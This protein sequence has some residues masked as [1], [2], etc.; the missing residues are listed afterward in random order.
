MFLYLN[1]G[2]GFYQDMVKLAVPIILQNLVI[3]SLS[4]VDTF[5]VG[6][7]PGDTPMAAV[8]LAN[9]PV[10]MIQL[11]IFGLQSGASVLISQYWGK[12]DTAAIN[13]VLGIGL[14]AA[15]AISLPF[16][17]AMFC[18]PVWSMGLFSNNAGLVAEAAGYAQIVGFAYVLNSLT[19]VYIG[20]QRSMENPSTGLHI[21]ILSMCT[22]TFLNWVLIFGRLGAPAMGVRGAAA[23][24]LIS[25]MVEF[26][27]TAAYA[28]GCRRFSLRA[29]LMLRP[30]GAMLRSYARFSTPVVL[31]ETLWGLGTALYPTIMG[32]MAESTAILTAFTIAGNIDRVCTVAVFALANTAAII[33]GREIGAGRRDG[34]Y[35][36]GGALNAVAFGTGLILGGIM[37]ASTYLII[38]P[39]IYPLFH[40]SERAAAIS[41]MMQ[42]VT[43]AFLA[44]R[45]FNAV[46]IVGVLRGGGD[47]RAATIIDL[48]PLWGLALPLFVLFGMVLKLD[49]FWV[50]LCISAENVIKF[51][52]GIY[53]FRSRAW[54]ND[55]TRGSSVPVGPA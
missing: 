36:T 41:T 20:A 25:R 2:K 19:Q 42:V 51:F 34:V 4:L 14:Y 40:L 46:N 35:E 6:R 13:R 24:T 53:R 26:A 48:V 49:I 45:S 22:N 31:N 38:A 1:R 55:V 54:I 39:Y 23:A 52:L 12:G 3:S 28:A 10:F 5:M 47:V 7:L 29:D 27:V 32:H 30:G 9:I 18:F 50:F 21:S 11:V 17:L 43:A 33:V 44:V 8:T 15:A 37:V 16:A